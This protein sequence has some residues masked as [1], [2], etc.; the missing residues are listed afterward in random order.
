MFHAYR[1]T[2]ATDCGV[3]CLRM[4]ARHYGQSYKEG[5]LARLFHQ[6]RNGVSLLDISEAAESIGL[7][8]VGVKISAEQL[9]SEAPLPCILHWNQHHFVVCYKVSRRFGK[10]L[11]HIADPA[12][13]KLTYTL[14]EMK[15]CWGRDINGITQG[16]ALLLEPTPEFGKKHR[17]ASRRSGMRFLYSY[18]SLHRRSIMQVLLAMFTISALQLIAP[19]LTQAMVDVGIGSRNMHMVSLILMA[20][21]TVFVSTLIVGVIRSWVV[22]YMNTRIN[23]S[24]ISDFLA[25]LMR[26]PFR[27][28]DIRLMGDIVQRIR[29]NDRIE[30]FLTGSSISTLFSMVN[31]I[32][33]STILFFYDTTILLTFI[34][35]NAL[36]VAWT[37][38][39]MRY[40]RDLDLKRFNQLADEQDII[41]QIIG[42]IRDIKLANCERQKRWQWEHI[43]AAQFRTK[44]KTL[45]IAQ[46]Q[47]L[48]SLFF[49]QT[50]SILVAWLAA[51][52][53]IDGS[54]TLG[55]MMAVS[56][57]IGQIT[58]PIN[59][60]I[61][62]LSSLQ[63]ARISLERLNEIHC[64]DDEE[65]LTATQ[66]SA[67]LP[68]EMSLTLSNVWFSYSGSKRRSVLCDISLHIPAHKVTAIV[69][70]SG[71]GKTTLLKMI[72]GFY[73]PD[74]GQILVGDTPLHDINPHTWRSSVGGVLQDG[75][76]FSDDIAHNIALGDD[77]IDALR[78]TEA[79]RTACI[80]DYISSLPMAYNTK[81]GM[82]GNGL[83][84]G[85]K[86]RLLIARAV[87]KNPELLILDEATN[88]LDAR[89]EQ[90]I[91]H[92]MQHFFKGRTVI[93]AA[94][95]LS[96][97]VN[98][99]NIVVMADGKIVEQG[100][101]RQLM[102]QHGEYYN[103]VKNQIG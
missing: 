44:V 59:S 53:V 31:F 90:E 76:I 66:S 24:L 52:K 21:L 70:A 27:F 81:T 88:A 22:L 34:G 9:I 96:T 85:Q 49:S 23:I 58:S 55:M 98:A 41:F 72:L 102:E 84:Q 10:T 78:M 62:F 35:G 2:D 50:T 63:Y 45:S 13:K 57:I 80:H 56:Y 36:Y 46:L 89:N 7:H 51:R 8:T 64:S 65:Q 82:D 48:G 54:M 4:V 40:R 93:V 26:M 37:Q 75:Y 60:F 101:H 43:Q 25:K 79:A 47:Q 3:A 33:F 5:D 100:T 30:E 71:C 67:P 83:S 87:Y 69:G 68:Q 6:T 1:Q 16:I 17:P 20:Q 15:H 91:M 86:Q 32:V 11:F 92:N 39:F 42:G 28:F 14:D 94:H 73:T 61:D 99:D 38:L 77:D 19:F 12:S 18:F 74:S 97:I 29:D 103:L 95:R